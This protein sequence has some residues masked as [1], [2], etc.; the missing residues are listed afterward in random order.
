MDDVAKHAGVSRAL[1]S[2]VMRDSPRVSDHSRTKVLASA[3]ELG[4]RPNVWAR[5]LASGQTNT[6]GVMLNDFNNPY[7][8]ELAYGVAESATENGMEVLFT[9]G[10][11]REAGE[12]AAIDT[13]LNH[14]PDGIVLGAARIADDLFFDI[15]AQVATVA[16]SNFSRPDSMDTVCNDEAFGADLVVE[17]LTSLGHTRIAHID[18]GSSP[19][20]PQRRR[21]FSHAMAARGLAPIVFEGDYNE[22]AAHDAS[23][24]LMSLK[25]PPSAIFAANDLAASGVIAHLRDTGV[26]VPGD[27]SVVGYDDTVLAGLG[28]ISL[29]T[30]AQP[31][32]L[33]GRRS[34][35]LL[36][37]RIGG[38]DVAKHELLRPEL[39]VRSTTGPV[40]Q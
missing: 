34:T 35:E 1:V 24:Q 10:W 12:L 20:G 11:Q 38:R 14:R 40:A 25:E 23:V 21:G 16:V 6:I 30:V 17:H 2:L 29:T 8:A 4:Y 28:A 5:N 15:A 3:N 18:A 36:V 26:S 22:Q 19:G 32:K 39:V 7:F 9:S 13:L 31:M 33:A 27:V 37:E